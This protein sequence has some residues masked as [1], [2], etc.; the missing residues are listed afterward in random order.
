MQLIECLK[1]IVSFFSDFSI[2][3]MLKKNQETANNHQ[4]SHKQWNG[5]QQKLFYI[6]FLSGLSG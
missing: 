6:D 1:I 3:E 5:F 2:F 4:R